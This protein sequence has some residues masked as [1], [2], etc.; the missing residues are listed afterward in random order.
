MRRLSETDECSFQWRLLKQSF[1]PS[2]SFFKSF[3]HEIN[4]LNL[5][6]KSSTLQLTSGCLNL[7]R[8]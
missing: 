1:V 3:N 5:F 2:A 7:K 4:S 6:E 8:K